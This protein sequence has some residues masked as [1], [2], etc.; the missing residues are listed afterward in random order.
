[1]DLPASALTGERL[2]ELVGGLHERVYH[3]EPGEP[4]FDETLP[5][6]CEPRLVPARLAATARADRGVLV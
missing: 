4:L 5:P 6:G 2:R 1:M 3:N